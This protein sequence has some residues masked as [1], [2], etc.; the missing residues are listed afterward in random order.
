MKTARITLIAILALAMLLAL[1]AIAQE[2][3]QQPDAPQ[4]LWLPGQRFPAFDLQDAINIDLGKMGHNEAYGELLR[5]VASPADYVG[6]ILR[7]TGEYF[8]QV[9]ADTGEIT[10]RI[11]VSDEGVCCQVGLG[12]VLTGEPR[13]LEELPQDYSLIEIAGVWGMMDVGG[14]QYPRLLVNEIT[15]LEPA[16]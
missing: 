8:H 12:F 2:A 15:V 7:L 10:H 4:Q 14:Q 5:M 6:Q 9:D 11:V 16:S 3:T 13:T 1:P